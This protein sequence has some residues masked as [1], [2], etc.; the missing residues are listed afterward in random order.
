MNMAR[1]FAGKEYKCKQCDSIFRR[2]QCEIARGRIHYCSPKCSGLAHTGVNSPTY[3]RGYFLNS[4]GYKRIRVGNTY[5][6]EHRHLV[7][8]ALGR[9]LTNDEDVHHIDGDKLHNTLSNLEVLSKANHARKHGNWLGEKNHTTKLTAEKVKEIREK[10]REGTKASDLAVA[11][12][13]DVS[14][15]RYIVNRVTWKHI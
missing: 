11:Y 1:P 13:V 6:Y 4:Y 7:E 15:I 5:K 10:F 12:N 14:N 2:S 9:T 3:K 8:E